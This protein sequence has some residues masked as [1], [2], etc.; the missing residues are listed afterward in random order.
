MKAPHQLRSSAAQ[1]RSKVNLEPQPSFLWL[2][3]CTLGLWLLL[4]AGNR[5]F[6]VAEWPLVD[7]PDRSLLGAGKLWNPPLANLL[8][9]SWLNSLPFWIIAIFVA[10]LLAGGADGALRS[11]MPWPLLCLVFLGLVHLEPQ[12]SLST[13]VCMGLVGRLAWASRNQRIDCWLSLILA[14]ALFYF[15]LAVTLEAGLVA[16]VLTL[17]VVLP[18]IGRQ[19]LARQAWGWLAAVCG[20][21]AV[22]GLP[23]LVVEGYGSFML[24]WINW[25][26]LQPPIELLPSMGPL[27]LAADFGWPHVCGL[28]LLAYYW[29]LALAGK[30]DPSSSLLTCLLSLIGLGCERYFWL[31]MLTLFL[32]CSPQLPA[33]GKATEPAGSWAGGARLTQRV[34]LIAVLLLGGFLALAVQLVAHSSTILAADVI[35]RRLPTSQWNFSGAVLLTNLEQV[36]DWQRHTSRGQRGQL[37]FQPILS[38]R[39]EVFHSRYRDYAAVCRDWASWKREA[40]LRSD[41]RWGGYQATFAEW[42]PVLV[43][44]DSR[45]LDSIH[46]VSLDS[47]WKVLGID[48]IRTMFA[49]SESPA[50]RAYVQYANRVLLTAEF[51]RPVSDVDFAR[52]LSLGDHAEALRVSAVLTSLRLPFAALRVLPPVMDAATRT[53]ASF[54][55]AE[56]ANRAHRYSGSFSVLDNVRALGSSQP[57]AGEANLI[58]SVQRYRDNLHELLAQFERDRETE[59]PAA[60]IRNALLQG[61][62]QQAQRS[63]P[64]LDNRAAAEFYAVLAAAAHQPAAQTLQQLQSLSVAEWPAGL[65]TERSFYIGCLANE[66]GDVGLARSALAEVDAPSGSVFASVVHFYRQQIE[67]EY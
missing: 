57:L 39:W 55:Y 45:D 52:V 28:L 54:A 34:A 38:D 33:S 21:L 1:A 42:K 46:A 5:Y 6:L 31:A 2:G 48:P 40:Y 24:R 13:L 67:N 19:R 32:T 12:N 36:A 50:T 43:V 62:W 23:G 26:W 58:D 16:C 29:Q 17:Q 30:L 47:Q 53:S 49:Q 11:G 18:A 10:W 37:Q 9:G 56:L 35:G 60:D 22:V 51:P 15:A 7:A 66:L 63:L 27:W 59:S 8:D 14:A 64:Q 65:A 61:R 3:C 41:G 25:L 4:L 20:W 44:V